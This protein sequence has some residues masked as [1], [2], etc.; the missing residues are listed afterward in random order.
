M[1]CLSNSRRRVSG[2]SSTTSSRLP[3]C[4]STLNDAHSSFPPSERSYA[5]EN[6]PQ[7]PNCSRTSFVSEKIPFY[8]ENTGH[9]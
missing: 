3:L 2:P 8:H 9:A 6:A 4:W 7:T 1:M 5:D